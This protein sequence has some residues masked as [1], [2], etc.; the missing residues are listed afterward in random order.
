VPLLNE[1]KLNSPMAKNSASGCGVNYH[2]CPADTLQDPS[3]PFAPCKMT[4]PAQP[5]R[6]RGAPSNGRQRCLGPEIA[7]CGQSIGTRNHAR[8]DDVSI[9]PR[10][11]A[12]PAFSRPRTCCSGVSLIAGRTLMT[13]NLHRFGAS[14]A[15]VGVDCAAMAL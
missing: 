15:D 8:T 12:V 9:A 10:M 5:Q 13:V 2:V 4:A 3:H 6:Q 11:D 1:L 7:N 14:S